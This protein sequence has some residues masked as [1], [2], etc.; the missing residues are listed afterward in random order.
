MI[1]SGKPLTTESDAAH[2]EADWPLGD[3]LMLA[4]V[5]DHWGA[6]S[7]GLGCLQLSLFPAPALVW[8]SLVLLRRW[9]RD[10]SAALGSLNMFCR[11]KRWRNLSRLNIRFVQ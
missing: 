4:H 5:I 11:S 7:Q 10:L 6:E 8:A 2:T 1:D 3:G 9:D